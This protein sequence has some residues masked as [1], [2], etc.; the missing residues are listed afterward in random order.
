MSRQPRIIV[1]LARTSRPAHIAFMRI[2]RLLALFCFALCSAPPANAAESAASVT[3]RATVML[4]S[5]T[6]AV[7]PGTQYHLGL[8]FQMAPGWHTYGRNPGDAGLPPELAWTLPRGTT[9]GD[10]AWPTPTRMPE[11]PLMTFGYTGTMMLVL[12]ASGP[13]PIRL[14][15]SWLICSNICVPEEADFMLDLPVGT[16]SPS[17]ESPFFAG[18]LEA[19]PRASPFE[20]HIGPDG[21]LSLT[22]DRLDAVR[23]AYFFPD[24]P[25]LVSPT[26]AQT[27]GRADKG[28]TLRLPTGAAFKADQPLAGVLVLRDASGQQTSLSVTAPPGAVVAAMSLW[29]A[30]GFAVLGGLILNLMPCVFPVLAMKAL[31]IARLSVE[32]RSVARRH[33]G[34]Y[35]L[36]VMLSFALIGGAVLLLRQLG[37]GVGWGFQFQSPVFVAVMAWVLFA[38]G[39]NLSGV[40]GVGG[41]LANAGQGLTLAG[42]GSGSFFSGALAV[43]V[44]TPCTAPFMGVALA[45]AFAAPPAI[46]LLL[47]LAMGAGL[48]APTTILAFIPAVARALPRPGR[49]MET[50]RQLLAFPMYAGSAWLIWVISLQAGSPGV[51]AVAAGLV[52][53]GFAGW[54]LGLG[55]RWAMGLAL[56]AALGAV[57]LLPGIATSDLP[58]A[59]SAG[60]E[61]F[62]PARLASLRAEGK[63]VFV[64]MTAAWCVSC[65]VNERV[66]LAPERVRQA[67]DSAGVTLLKGDWT[68]QDPDISAFL[69]SQGRDGVPLYMYYP[70]GG[71]PPVTLPQLLTQADVLA[72]IR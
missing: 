38:V 53:I 48:A 9:V 27:F 20:A 26:G 70:A 62:T 57:A 5:D 49:W 25:E 23:D 68:R 1:W 35:A 60:T 16:S 58:Q 56:V 6:D 17:A 47:F 61:R 24:T 22:G 66:A 21:T 52:L 3:K 71:K 15:A 13:G 51:L 4:M 37:H 40:F 36:G 32:A 59:E 55:R 18:A 44:A 7:A 12:P 43:L 72:V 46:T 67:F 19:Q 8:R 2:F 63:P 28:I 65:L 39:L 42:G 54:A 41:R 69:Q 14:H 11:G 33:A 29:R 10:I 31:A 50:L 64:N 34:L 30:I 45:A